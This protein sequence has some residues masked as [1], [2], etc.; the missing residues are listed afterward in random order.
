MVDVYRITNVAVSTAGMFCPD[1]ISEGVIAGEKN[2]MTSV[3]GKM[4]SIEG[5]GIFYLTGSIK[6]DG[7]FDQQVVAIII[8]ITDDGIDPGWSLSFEILK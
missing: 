2:I 8:A 3:G 4:I 7:V 5:C 1:Q 6:I